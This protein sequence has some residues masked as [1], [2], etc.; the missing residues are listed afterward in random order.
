MMRLK[1]AIIGLVVGSILVVSGAVEAQDS[2]AAGRKIL[3]STKN[4]VIKVKLVVQQKML[5]NGKE[6]QSSESKSEVTGTVVDPSG[7][8]AVSL[9]SV[10]PSKLMDVVMGNM[11]MGENKV[12]TKF[13]LKDVKLIL[14][15]ETEIDAKVVLRDTDWDLAFLR[16]TQKPAK[17][18]AAVDMKLQ[19]QPQVLDEVIVVKRLAKVANHEPGALASR[20]AAVVRKP[21]LFYIPQDSSEATE[22]LGSPVFTVDGKVV[23]IVL[24]RMMES[25]GGGMTAMLGGAGGMGITSII[26][27]ADQV[28][29]A[30][31]Q[32]GDEAKA[33]DKPVEKPEKATG[34]LPG[35][36]A[37]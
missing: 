17:P 2:S 19:S 10:D 20:I 32:A 22:A 5:M 12:E 30:S 21:R 27:P 36:G 4:A 8:V 37:K 25:K 26:L 18:L 13:Q 34:T 15:D 6:M 33:D 23:G 16:P 7:L 3:E 14:P 9:S 31:K 11:N 29:E 1:N 35:T 28:L 24:M